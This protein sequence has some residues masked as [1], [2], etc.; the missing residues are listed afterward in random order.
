MEKTESRT[1]AFERTV[2]RLLTYLTCSDDSGLDGFSFC[3]DVLKE[4]SPKQ[5][6]FTR[7]PLTYFNGADP[8][9]SFAEFRQQ[10]KTY[11]RLFFM[12]EEIKPSDL[13]LADWDACIFRLSQEES[14]EGSPG[15][16]NDGAVFVGR[17]GMYHM[18]RVHRVPLSAVRGMFKLLTGVVVEIAQA[19]IYKNGT[20]Q[21]SRLYCELRDG[22]W[23]AVGQPHAIVPA[24]VDDGTK[25]VIETSKTLS[26]TS[27][28]DWRVELSA[29]PDLPSISFV[30][31][32]I[33]SR[34]IFRLRDIPSGASRRAALRHWV[35][36][37]WRQRRDDPTEDQKIWPYLRGSQEFSWNGLYCKIR[38][39]KHDLRKAT[40][41]GLMAA[42]TKGKS[43]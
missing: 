17:I 3:G 31:D 23:W 39:S 27:Y 32:P 19:D 9:M 14:N 8:F 34:E 18:E 22:K 5:L 38:P 7:V 30:T 33:G 26:F 21:T 20:F 43:A 37:H 1:A 25:S 41:Y 28:Y 13:A 29:R 36:G 4:I 24:V 40:E 12:P 10:T 35:N 16:P 42:K 15:P 11:T 6:S 2:D